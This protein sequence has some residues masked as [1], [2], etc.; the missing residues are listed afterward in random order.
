MRQPSGV[1]QK[2]LRKDNKILTRKYPEYIN[3]QPRF[4]YK[5][6]YMD[7]IHVLLRIFARGETKEY[8][9]VTIP[10]GYDKQTY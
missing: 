2:R 6:Y 8:F 1:S 4:T 5:S 10:Y 9:P 7:N 3:K